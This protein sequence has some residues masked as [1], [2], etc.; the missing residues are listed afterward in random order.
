MDMKV[1]SATICVDGLKFQQIKDNYYRVTFANFVPATH[2]AYQKINFH[3]NGKKENMEPGLF[4]LDHFLRSSHVG[5]LYFSYED[6][7]A[8]ILN[9]GESARSDI[10]DLLKSINLNVH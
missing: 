6:G 1:G 5:N 3:F 9:P 10:L 4:T 7:F 2:I 8:V